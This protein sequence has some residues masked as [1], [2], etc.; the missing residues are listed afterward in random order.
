MT[1]FVIIVVWIALTVFVFRNFITVVITVKTIVYVITF[2]IVLPLSFV[3]LY[4]FYHLLFYVYTFSQILFLR[5]ILLSVIK[6]IIYL[7]YIIFEFSYFTSCSIYQQLFCNKSVALRTYSLGM[8]CLRFFCVLS[9]ANALIFNTRVSL[10]FFLFF[11]TNNTT[12][13]TYMLAWEKRV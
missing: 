6:A 4:L 13:A 7:V 10:T 3:L 5:L 9:F 1:Y 8:L 2:T 12:F 11:P